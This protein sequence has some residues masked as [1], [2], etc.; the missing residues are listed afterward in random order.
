LRG[1][2]QPG[3]SRFGLASFNSRKFRQLLFQAEQWGKKIAEFLHS[4]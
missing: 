4:F 3:R 2:L 1:N